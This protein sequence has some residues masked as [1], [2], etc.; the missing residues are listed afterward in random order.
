M[1]TKKRIVI[2][3]GGTAGITVAAQL[4]NSGQPLDVTI[5][6]PSEKH[7]YQPLWTLVGGG[8]FPR[9]ESERNESDYIPRDANWVKDFVDSFDP[10]N[11]SMKTRG[12]Q[13]IGYDFLV[14][15]PGLQLNWSAIK[16]LSKEIV[17]TKRNLQ[18]L[19]L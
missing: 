12:G 1:S 15:C 14:V 17:G 2:V 10:D 4:L 7:Y 16:G 19:Q 13:S 9:E 6:E 5:I 18:Q 3:G 8:I 11:N